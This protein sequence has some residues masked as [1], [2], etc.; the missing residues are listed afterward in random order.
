MMV[1]EV[2]R[3]AAVLNWRVRG[4]RPMPD[5]SG[6]SSCMRT[7]ERP[8]LGAAAFVA[9]AWGR[10][11]GNR[12]GEGCARRR[13]FRRNFVHAGARSPGV[14]FTPL[15]FAS[16]NAVFSGV[17]RVPKKLEK[18]FVHPLAPE[19]PIWYIT[20]PLRPKGP[21]PKR[22]RDARSLI[23]L[24]VLKERDPGFPPRGNLRKG[25]GTHK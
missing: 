13:L 10:K 15:T 16:R 7:G 3:W 20:H 21:R 14:G 11:W 2:V 19:R 23:G 25:R 24:T 8:R 5:E 1:A 4:A 17:S 12:R 9:C 6:D 22:L 18:S